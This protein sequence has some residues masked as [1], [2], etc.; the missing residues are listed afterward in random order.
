MQHCLCDNI[1]K[2]YFENRLIY[3]NAACREGKGTDFARDRLTGFLREHYK[4]HGATGYILK[5]DIRH[6]FDSIDH[7]ILK[8]MLR[9]I[10]DRNV[11]GL[12]FHIIRSY[13]GSM[14]PATG[15]KKGLPLGNQTSQWF[16]LYYLD[17]MDRLIKEKMRI[18]HYI[19]YMDDGVLIHESREY[20]NEVL[21]RM[22]ENAGELKLEFNQKTQIVTTF[23]T[24]PT[25]CQYQLPNK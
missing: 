12:L 22:R 15:R 18:K 19:R 2:P 20:L 13:E 7:E 21:G 6:Y 24:N 16:A 23:Q 3:D 14:D 5:Y 11:L 9:N 25:S 8:G 1:L 17:P 10:P 4:R